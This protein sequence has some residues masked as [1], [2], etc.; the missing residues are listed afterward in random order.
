M[1]TGFTGKS[2]DFYSDSLRKRD[3][4]S[5]NRLVEEYFPLVRH[6]ANRFRGSA[7]E[8]DDLLQEGLIGLLYA[9]RAYD[10]NRRVAFSTFAYRCITNR[11]LT[12]VSSAEKKPPGVSLSDP[13]IADSLLSGG[14]PNDPQEILIARETVRRWADEAVQMLSAFERKA[15]WLY[16]TGYS[17]CEASK[18]L[19][20]SEKKVDNALQRA[21]RKLRAGRK[22][23]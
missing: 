5:V 15:L 1:S 11:I 9:V 8:T 2:G 22:I 14:R 23:R 18:I 21:R 6:I 12:V 20:T 19:H 17:Y 13:Q 3:S 7:A 4:A 10:A 16:L